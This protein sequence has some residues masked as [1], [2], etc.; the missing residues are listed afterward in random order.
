[1][2]TVGSRTFLEE[3][4]EDVEAALQAG[5]QVDVRG[6][7]GAPALLMVSAN[8]HMDVVKFLLDARASIERGPRWEYSFALGG[9]ERALGHLQGVS[10]GQS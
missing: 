6:Q 10:G 3:D 9:F 2:E 4:L 7:F 8:G 5:I 1:M